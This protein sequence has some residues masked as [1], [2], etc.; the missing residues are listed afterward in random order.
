MYFSNQVTISV[1]NTVPVFISINNI[2]FQR[3]LI[4]Y[5]FTIIIL[6]IF[7][8]YYI[9]Q[10]HKSFK[11]IVMFSRRLEVYVVLSLFFLE[12]FTNADNTDLRLQVT[13]VF[14]CSERTFRMRSDNYLRYLLLFR[15]CLD[16]CDGLSYNYGY[17]NAVRRNVASSCREFVGR[18]KVLPAV[19]RLV[20][21]TSN[22]Y[23]QR[24]GRVVYEHEI[25]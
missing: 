6:E 10:S 5:V 9:D 22:L 23:L 19:R 1:R 3:L 8:P 21:D 25:T 2:V 13:D 12:C 4:K 15:Q 14:S 18:R 17:C 7:T 11:S 24:I 16:N 20:Y